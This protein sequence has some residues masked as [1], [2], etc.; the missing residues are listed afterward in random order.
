[1]RDGMPV[2]IK[3]IARKIGKST[4]TV[5]RALHDYGDISPETKQLV[6][7]VAAELGYSPNTLAQR[8]QKQHTDTLALILPTYGPR[9]SDPFF[10]EFIAGVGNQATRQG[11]DLLVST[12]PPGEEELQAYQYNVQGRRVDGF[13]LVRIRCQD[14]R[15]DYLCQMGFPFVAYGSTEGELDFPLVDVDSRQGMALVVDYLAS[16]GHRRIACITPPMDLMF[17]RHRLNSV[18][19]SLES[20]GISC[21]ETLIVSSDLTQAGGYQQAQVLMDTPNPPSA[22]IAG[23][24]L[25]ALGA[26]SAVQERGLRVGADI[27]ITGF[28]DIAQAEHSHPPLTTVRQPIERIGEMV[29]EMLVKIIRKEPLEKEQIMLKPELVV[30]QSCGR[31]IA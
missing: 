1:M 14:A 19:A 7:Q 3:D 11:Y 16:L 20:Q 6:R 18:R 21:D 2:T 12:R 13:V 24:D 9:F 30:R 26:M 8:L 10:S 17:S 27:S 23:N 15:I 28:D 22:I 25:M 5:S 4:T 31:A 29:C